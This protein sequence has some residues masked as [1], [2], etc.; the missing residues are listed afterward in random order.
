MK[1]GNGI[2]FEYKR[3]ILD[4]GKRPEVMTCKTQV[5]EGAIQSKC[6]RN[7]TVGK[8]HSMCKGPEVEA[9][10]ACL[11]N[12]NNASHDLFLNNNQL[13]NDCFIPLCICK[14]LKQ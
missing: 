9:S 2:E 12:G 1:Q 7:S 10:L 11:D 3:G 8:R 13:R 5:L 4:M 14:I 6:L